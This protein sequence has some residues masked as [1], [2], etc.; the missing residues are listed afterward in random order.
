MRI[1]ELANATKETPRTLRF[2][3]TVGLLP[4]PPRAPDGYRNYES[5]AI[6]QVR[7][8]RSLQQTGLSLSDIATL[9][10]IRDKTEPPN[11]S[12]S[13]IL[14]SATSRLD[15]HLATI[16]RMR[17]DLASLAHSAPAPIDLKTPRQDAKAR[18]EMQTRTE[19]G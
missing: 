17:A 1:S 16:M 4:P 7:F 5:C 15:H 11:P 14:A 13:Q 19:K 12:D 2:Y 8:I 9:V 10:H 3:E 18:N 6:D